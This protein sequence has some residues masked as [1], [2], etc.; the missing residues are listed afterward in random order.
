MHPFAD[1]SPV[2]P[3]PTV[4]PVLLSR[5]EPMKPNYLRSGA[6]AEIFLFLV[7]IYYSQFWTLEDARMKKKQVLP[8][9]YGTNVIPTVEQL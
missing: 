4:Q 1:E 2:S 8:H 9:R 5:T 6:G 3:V 7:Y